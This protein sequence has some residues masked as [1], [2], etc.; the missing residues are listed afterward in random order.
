MVFNEPNEY[1]DSC[2]FYNI[3]KDIHFFLS[4]VFCKVENF[5]VVTS[6]QVKANRSNQCYRAKGNFALF[7]QIG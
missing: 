6:R 2:P 7:D 3:L 4:I 1:F 5:I